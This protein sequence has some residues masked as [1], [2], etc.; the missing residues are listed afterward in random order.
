MDTPVR[1][2]IGTVWAER[3]HQ[4][5]LVS[6]RVFS[7]A[8]GCAHPLGTPEHGEGSCRRKLRG[9]SPYLRISASRVLGVHPRHV[10]PLR[11]TGWGSCRR[12]WFLPFYPLTSGRARV[13]SSSEAKVRRCHLPS[14]PPRQQKSS[15]RFQSEGVVSGVVT[16]VTLPTTSQGFRGP[17]PVTAMRVPNGT[18]GCGHGAGCLCLTGARTITR[19]LLRRDFGQDRPVQCTGPFSLPSPH[20]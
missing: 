20:P 1:I 10:K 8:S 7:V 9:Q 18:V 15:R 13:D 5:G 11:P 6:R 16:H 2:G 12:G 19:T 3:T 14:E 4:S 17:S